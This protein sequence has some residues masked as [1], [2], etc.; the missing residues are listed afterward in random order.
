MTKQEEIGAGIYRILD[1]QGF[2]RCGMC[3]RDDCFLCMTTEIV[4]Y[5]HSLGVVIKVD[6]ELPSLCPAVD[7]HYE[8]IYRLGQAD[9]IDR[10]GYAAVESL[11]EE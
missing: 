5:L 4:E 3:G 1:T 8:H 6:R 2:P 11:I 10:G 9:L 7:P